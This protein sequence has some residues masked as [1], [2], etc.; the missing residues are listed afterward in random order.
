MAK[1]KKAESAG[2][3]VIESS[4]SKSEQFIEKN[5]KTL[6]II[7][8]VILI[9]VGIYLAV[10]KFHYEPMEEEAQQQVFA[11]IQYFEKDS[12]ELALHGDGNYIGFLEIIEDYS[13]TAAGNTA[14]Y[15]TGLC[16]LKSGQFEE[17]IDYLSSFSTDDKL[18]GSMALAAIGDAYAEM[19][20][21]EEALGYYLEAAKINANNFTSPVILMKAGLLYEEQGRYNEALDVY[22]TIKKEYPKSAEGNRS[23][24]DRYIERAKLK[25]NA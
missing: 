2:M 12:I 18:V 7:L 24:I 21:Y 19:G 1:K 8:L 14:N 16:F 10:K 23:V 6:S 5:Q 25:A 9:V 20:S 11:A 13:S 3:E 4:L 15:Y 22:E 17:A